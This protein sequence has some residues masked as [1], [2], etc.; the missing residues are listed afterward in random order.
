MQQ[1]EEIYYLNPVPSDPKCI[2][3]TSRLINQE[4]ER[5]HLQYQIIPELLIKLSITNEEL[6]DFI[7]EEKTEDNLKRL[8]PSTKTAG[9]IN[10]YKLLLII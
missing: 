10:D 3:I 2:Y 4:V 7:I 1:N 5:G 8:L 9:D 6:L